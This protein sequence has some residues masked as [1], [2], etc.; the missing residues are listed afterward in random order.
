M[1][2]NDICK[3]LGGFNS[4]DLTFS[5][6]NGEIYPYDIKQRRRWRKRIKKED[7]KEDRHRR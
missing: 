7:G 1:N 3:G 5:Y 6:K 2:K 4:L